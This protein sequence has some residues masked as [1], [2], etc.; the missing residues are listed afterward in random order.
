MAL[1]AAT[2]WALTA[3]TTDAHC[4][5][6]PEDLIDCNAEL[7][8]VIAPALTA[9]EQATVTEAMLRRQQQEALSDLNHIQLIQLDPHMAMAYAHVSRG[10]KLR[11]GDIVALHGAVLSALRPDTY[12]LAKRWQALLEM[13]LKCKDDI[14]CAWF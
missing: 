5:P 6:H 1:A 4:P 10:G 7:A 12:A 8:Q 2:I 9:Q 3:L 13:Y 11:I 14:A